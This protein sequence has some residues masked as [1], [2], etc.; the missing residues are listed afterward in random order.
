MP[1]LSDLWSEISNQRLDVTVLSVNIGD[2]EDVIRDWWR[3]G[4]FRHRAVRQ[5]RDEVS[6]AFDVDVYPT[7]FVID[8]DGRILYAAA[9]WDEPAVREALASTAD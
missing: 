5:D 6:R 3:E 4:G 7:N 1:H 2:S 9:G 8:G